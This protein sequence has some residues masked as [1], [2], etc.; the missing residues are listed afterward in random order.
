MN[1]KP[2]FLLI[3]LIPKYKDKESIL[4]DLEEL[5]SLVETYGGTVAAVSAQRSEYH[6]NATYIGSGK[7]QEAADIIAEKNIN[8]VVINALVKPGQ[9]FTLQKIFFRSNPNILVWDRV[10]LILHIFSQHAQ[11]SES[12]LQIELAQM[13]HMG[14]RIYGMGFVLSQQAGGIGTRGIGE[15]NTELMKRHWRIRMKQVADKLKTLQ[16]NRESQLA[17]R[18]RKGLTTVSIVGYTNAG[19]T[20]L[21]NILTGKDK[22]VADALFATLDSNVGSLFLSKN[23]QEVLLSDTIGFIKDLPHQLIN[24]F[25][26]TLLESVNA[27]LLLHVIDSSDPYIHEKIII[28]EKLLAAIHTNT[29]RKLYVFNK[30]DL[31]AKNKQMDLWKQYIHHTPYLVSVKTGFGITDLKHAIESFILEGKTETLPLS[32]YTSSP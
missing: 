20:S 27:D 32:H 10:E 24:A 2:K 28:V 5:Q 22:L 19:K 26:S 3:S 8:I 9:L 4:P 11:T 16:K 21:F 12:K 6:D 13:R 7:A 15:T 25:R 23:K 29:S 31:V 30:I 1:N 18:K 14:P 17:R